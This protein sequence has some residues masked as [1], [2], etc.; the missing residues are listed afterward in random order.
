LLHAAPRDLTMPGALAE[1]RRRFEESEPDVLAFLPEE[2]RWD[3][4]AAAV[5]A[6]LA[7]W[8]EGG[9][10]PALLG[11]PIGVKDI[12]H[13][14][15]FPTRAGTTLPPACFAG[16]QATAVTRLVAAG[17]IVVGKTVSTEIAFF[18][19]GPTRNPTAPG[20]TPGGSSSGSA[21]AVAA[22]LCPLALG[23]QTIGSI[24]RPAAYCGVVGFK[25]SY[26]R[27]PR[28]GV[29]P[30]APSLDH[31]GWLASD[32]GMAASVAAELCDRWRRA[33][34]VSARPTLGV[35]TGP[36]LERAT[37][38]A[39]EALERALARATAAGCAVR[40]V[41]VM[42]DF[43]AVDARHR[44]LV[45][46]EAWAEHAE[47]HARFPDRFHAETEALFARGRAADP[48]AIADARAGRERLRGALETTMR[49]AG[50]DL[51]IA[52]A[53]PGPPPEGLARTGDPVM[54]LP[55]THAGMP[56]LALPAGRDEG[57][58][59]GVQL[60]AHGGA[61]EELLAWG[62]ALAEIVAA[63]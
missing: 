39:R 52:P 3:R 62:A 44:L 18:A 4:I 63:A 31:V 33:V 9:W 1:L 5:D 21:A 24:C 17:A 58:P 30:L 26:E 15:G 6:A 53:A 34:A 55:W 27:V 60:V 59:F 8:P 11:L 32:V 41:A 10:R 42:P 45:A 36:Y 13:V 23:S 49:A 25:P 20:R 14:Q 50:I 46:A 48:A 28:A 19:P 29:V 54:N 12:F 35:P 7:H 47:R 51:W 38:G 56:A 61:D 40:R 2:G 57:L 43:D 16:P 22:G 37:P